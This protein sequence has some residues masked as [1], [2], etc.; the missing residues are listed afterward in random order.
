MKKALLLIAMSPF[1]VYARDN[2]AA[3]RIGTGIVVVIVF[4]AIMGIVN[5]LKEKKEAPKFTPTP[6]PTPSYASV[7]RNDLRSM[8]GA[9]VTS[10]GGDK[11]LERVIHNVGV[12]DIVLK[13]TTARNIVESYGKVYDFYDVNG[14]SMEMKY[15][16]QDFS[17]FFLQSDPDMKIHA[18]RMWKNCPAFKR[19]NDEVSSGFSE[20]MS[21]HDVFTF[22]RQQ[23]QSRKSYDETYYVDYGFYQYHF[24]PDPS[25]PEEYISIESITIKR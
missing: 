7:S 17:C 6:T 18:V 3:E 9:Q 8:L 14:Y 16:L 23:V 1:A 10:T 11:M 21:L 15:M 19:H 2:E 4:V 12:D 24:F 25:A 22:Y 20:T 13:Q 5:W